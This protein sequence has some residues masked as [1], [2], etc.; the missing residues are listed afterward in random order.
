MVT[1]IIIVA[2]QEKPSIAH[3]D[4]TTRRAMS[5][6]NVSSVSQCIALIVLLTLGHARSVARARGEDEE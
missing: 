3:G 1:V 4:E 2:V 6:I 5:N